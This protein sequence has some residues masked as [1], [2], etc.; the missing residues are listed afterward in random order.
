MDL[1]LR[2]IEI[3]LNNN[4]DSTYEQYF[5]TRRKLEY[6]VRLMFAVTV[7]LVIRRQE[8]GCRKV[9]KEV[10][11]GTLG[12]YIHSASA[13]IKKLPP[14]SQPTINIGNCIGGLNYIQNQFSDIW[15]TDINNIKNSRNVDA[16]DGTPPEKLIDFIDKINDVLIELEEK[17]NSMYFSV[18][19]GFGQ[20]KKYHYY[21]LL[22]KSFSETT[23]YYTCFRIDQYGQS[24]K[25]EVPGDYLKRGKDKPLEQ[26]FLFITPASTD[27]SV[28][29]YF[30]LSPFI[31]LKNIG[32]YQPMMFM[33]P[34]QFMNGEARCYRV[35]FSYGEPDDFTCDLSSL[36]D[37]RDGNND[38]FNSVYNTGN[39]RSKIEINKSTYFGFDT[40]KNQTLDYCKE[41]CP[42][43]QE[44]EQYCL[45]GDDS[46]RII[47]GDGGLGKTALTF[48]IIH[49]LILDGQTDFTRVIFLSAKKQVINTEPT[50]LGK[51]GLNIKNMPDIENYRSFLEKLAY[52]MCEN[53]ETDSLTDEELKDRLMVFINGSNQNSGDTH[54]PVTF[55]VIDDLDTFVKNDQIKVVD[56]LSKV[57]P[58]R[59]HA[60]ITT[61]HPNNISGRK[62]TLHLLSKKQSVAFLKWCRSRNGSKNLTH[63]PQQEA[64]LMFEYTGGRPLEIKFWN[65]V[66]RLGHTVPVVY[67]TFWNKEQKLMYLYRTVLQQYEEEQQQTVS[68]IANIYDIYKKGNVPDGIVTVTFLDYIY[69]RKNRKEIEKDLLMLEGILSLEEGEIIRLKED[70]DILKLVK[71]TNIP[72]FPEWCDRLLQWIKQAPNKWSA[73]KFIRPLLSCLTTYVTDQ[74]AGHDYELA[75]LQSIYVDEEK[76]AQLRE[77][78][79]DLL[80][81]TVERYALMPISPPDFNTSRQKKETEREIEHLKLRVEELIR[82]SKSDRCNIKQLRKDVKNFAISELKSL[83]DKTDLP[84]EQR[85]K[86][87]E[88]KDQ[89]IQEL[90]IYLID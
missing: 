68:L 86:I 52:Y 23:G 16:H 19:E 1:T 35:P 44:A 6:I 17:T 89:F 85:A 64:D 37:S 26:L 10:E 75:I 83:I 47:C 55:L 45:D 51:P 48:Y 33:R 88:V 80:K 67:E 60:L 4:E 22:V 84:A 40:I 34:L 73:L 87:M 2:K 5:Y 39:R 27:S 46:Y 7:D 38:K 14:D 81:R 43:V 9:L 57:S 3:C 54:C 36:I 32:E 63:I 24:K 77:D 65:S 12:A 59:I 53:L 82:Q 62:I 29:E 74:K 56:F 31:T 72:K 66:E 69:P 21:Y 41:I 90:K 28:I 11:N 25:I 71:E 42:E 76:M 18:S 8:D 15:K 78:E 13:L 49:N 30:R 79:Q 61:R 50:C 20:E 58:K 70:M